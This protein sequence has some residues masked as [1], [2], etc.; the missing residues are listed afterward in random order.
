MQ[1]IVKLSFWIILRI[2]ICPIGLW[3]SPTSSSA[4]TQKQLSTQIQ[5]M[6]TSAGFGSQVGYYWQEQW[7][8]GFQ[9]LSHT[10]VYTEQHKYQHSIYE[11]AKTWIA[12]T[13][14]FPFSENAF[15]LQGGITQLDWEHVITL[16]RDFSKNG[17]LLAYGEM[18]RFRYTWP[19]WG[20]NVGFGW[21]WI[22]NTSLSGGLGYSILFSEKPQLKQL[23]T[24]DETTPY[25]LEK[26]NAYVEQK[27]KEFDKRRT[28]LAFWPL[29]Y[30]SLGWNF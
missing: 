26:E 18:A 28:A 6:S 30:V 3:V 16:R 27:K 20:G 24:Q 10:N 19:D 14:Y 23:V 15:F 21:N 7:F 2:G 5:V 17:Q 1:S 25:M 4:E 11:Q 9:Y 29:F 22:A 8:L 12:I 13:R